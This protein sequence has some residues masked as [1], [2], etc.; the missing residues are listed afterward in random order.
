MPYDYAN[1]FGY[2]FGSGP[3]EGTRMWDA[4]DAQL[5]SPREEFPHPVIGAEG[6]DL[7]QLMLQRA[8]GQGP[9]AAALMT[10]R[11]L[12][13]VLGKERGY[14]A[15]ARNVSPGLAMLRGGRKGASGMAQVVQ[16][17]VT[18]RAQEQANAQA[19][20]LQWLET[21]EKLRLYQDIARQKSKQQSG[22]LGPAIKSVADW[23]AKLL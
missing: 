21:Q 2:G 9:S 19:A 10:G 18:E 22:V 5:N 16:Q 6:A 14:T 1:P 13:D 12:G 15:G 8:A 17:G 7:Q 3:N 4:F 20:L 11:G 23:V